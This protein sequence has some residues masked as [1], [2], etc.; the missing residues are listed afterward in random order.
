[1]RN[2]QSLFIRRRCLIYHLTNTVL[3][4]IMLDD[5]LMRP[6]VSI[7]SIMVSPFGFRVI[8]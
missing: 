1:M 6:L 7:R 5:F 3:Q 2:K 4:T 8:H